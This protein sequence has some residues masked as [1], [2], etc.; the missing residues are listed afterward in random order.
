MNKHI[1]PGSQNCF[2]SDIKSRKQHEMFKESE[3]SVI[4]YFCINK[5]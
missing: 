4:L 5:C 3:K 1:E 2:L